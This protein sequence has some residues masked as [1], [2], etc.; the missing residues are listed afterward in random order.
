MSK[1]TKTMIASVLAVAVAGPAAADVKENG[2]F[3]GTKTTAKITPSG[4]K[5]SKVDIAQASLYFEDDPGYPESGSWDFTAFNTTE[6]ASMDGW[7]IERK[8]GKDLTAALDSDDL[9]GCFP[10]GIDGEDCDGIVGQIQD[11]LAAE[12]CGAMTLL[13]GNAFTVTKGQIK[14]SKNG[15]RAKLD[16]QVEGEYTDTKSK[17][18]K[19]KAT[20]KAN[21]MDFVAD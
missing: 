13:Q 19:V 9:G 4:C 17:V 14:L 16:M 10:V 7:Y 15:D 21:K 8:V 20:V 5:N 6:S 1:F 18:K 12:S 2:D 3:V 11:H